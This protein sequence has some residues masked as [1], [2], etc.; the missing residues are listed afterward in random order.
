M[1]ANVMGETRI[2]RGGTI[3]LIDGGTNLEIADCA[4]A[5]RIA[6]GRLRLYPGIGVRCVRSPRFYTRDL[7]A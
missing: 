2:A 3:H 4:P 5:N 6:I 1:S 7:N